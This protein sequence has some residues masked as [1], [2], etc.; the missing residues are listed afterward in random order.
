MSLIVIIENKTYDLSSFKNR[1]PGGEKMISVFSG[2]DA[3]NAFQSYHGRKFPHEK[4]KKYLK[5]ELLDDDKSVLMDENYLKLH[6]DVKEHL[7]K[8][9]RTDGRAPLLQWFK[10]I[11]IIVL[12]VLIEWRTIINCK[13]SYG[14]AFLMGLL[15]AFIGLNIQ[16]DANHGAL[17]NNSKVNEY[18]GYTQNYIGGS[19][20]MWMYQHIVLHHQFTNNT[21]FDPDIQG[22]G[23]LR[24]YKEK[25]PARWYHKYQ[26][27]YIFLLE[28]FFG[29]MIV[30][31][32]PL[33][34]Y[35]N[36][37]GLT[38]KLPD[39]V[40]KWRKR[41]IIMNILFL[42]RFFALPYLLFNDTFKQLV[43]KW[44]ITMTVTGLYLS[45]FFS[46]SHNFNG[47]VM[48]DKTEAN[49]FAKQQIESS[50]NV[51]GEFLCHLNGG[52]NYQIEHHLFPRIAHTYY[53]YIAP[54]VK[55]WCEK[56][57]I[58]YTHYPTIKENVKALVDRLFELGTRN[59]M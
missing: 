18:I 44:C 22:A 9:F 32:T 58:K 12:T 48:F 27:K 42:I 23:V 39:T 6:A 29:Y 34:L 20:L 25:T 17:S 50:S 31:I 5:K 10:M 30:A 45:F 54:L 53:P 16:H 11:S 46:L 28:S 51:G 35:I 43:I 7:K 38:H 52:L 14:E 40:N 13:R 24:L 21:A 56:N 41:E 33:E 49:N 57:N 59:V 36:R 26:N 19:A 2:S 4:M 8:Y 3:T 37:Y 55:D 1:H 15:Y 47:T